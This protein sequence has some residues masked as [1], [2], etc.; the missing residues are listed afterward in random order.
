VPC[1]HGRFSAIYLGIRVSRTKKGPTTVNIASRSGCDRCV[2]RA[3]ILF[4]WRVGPTRSPPV[5][6]NRFSGRGGALITYVQIRAGRH[7]RTPRQAKVADGIVR[8]AY[9]GITGTAEAVSAPLPHVFGVVEQVFSGNQKPA[10]PVKIIPEPLPPAAVPQLLKTK[11]FLIVLYSKVIA[12]EP[13]APPP[14]SCP[15][16]NWKVAVA[17]SA[18]V[19]I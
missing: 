13:T 5:I 1:G 18:P 3:E 11:P 8:A 9:P 19:N 15:P 10:L 16:P 14:E 6:L 2:F 7:T 4:L 17:P 12:Q